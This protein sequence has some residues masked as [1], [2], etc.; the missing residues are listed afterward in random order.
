MLKNKICGYH[1]VLGS[2]E[3]DS[4]DEVIKDY[5]LLW[6]NHGVDNFN[7]LRYKGYDLK[8][9]DKDGQADYYQI[10]CQLENQINAIGERE[11]C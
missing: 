9:L 6:I 10:E 8:I 11:G 3:Y 7:I 2:K 4:I 1:E 5:F